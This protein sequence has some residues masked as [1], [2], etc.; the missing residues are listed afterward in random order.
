[1]TVAWHVI[2]TTTMVKAGS[3]WIIGLVLFL[4]LPSSGADVSEHEAR[5]KAETFLAS[6]T[7]GTRSGAAMRRVALNLNAVAETDLSPL[8][9][10]NR[11]GGGYVVVSGDS[12]TAEILAFS[13]TGSLQT[14]RMPANLRSCLERYARRIAQIPATAPALRSMAS[15]KAEI[16]PRMKT[17]WDQDDPYNLFTPNLHVVWKDMVRDVHAATGCVATGMAQ[18]LYYYQYPDATMKATKAFSGIA[19]VPVGSKEKRVVED[20]VRVA[21]QAEAVPEGSVIDW[22]NITAVYD[23]WSTEKECEA[24]ARLMQYC[25]ASVWMHYGMESGA[26]TDSMTYALYETFGYRDVYMIHSIEYPDV[27]SWG[28]AVY[29]E[30]SQAGPCPFSG[31]HSPESSAAQSESIGHLWILDGY[32]YV[33]GNDYFYSNWGWSGECNGYYLLDVMSPDE[34]MKDSQGRRVSYSDFQ[35]LYCGLGPNGEALRKGELNI[36]CESSVIGSEGK[37]YRRKDKASDF[38]VGDYLICFENLHFPRLNVIPALGIYDEA[39]GLVDYLPFSGSAGLSIPLMWGYQIY[40]ENER[41]PFYIGAGLENGVYDIVPICKT[42]EEREWRWMQNAE[43]YIVRM[44][45]KGNQATFGLS[46]TAIIPMP[47]S[48]EA[49]TD[50]W[51]SLSGTRYTRQPSVKGLYIKDGRK[52]FVK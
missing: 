42:P 37:T 45:V 7:A 11:E 46:P 24:V 9:A 14:E 20:T 49:E 35:S 6:R 44:T 5:R 3:R 32:R 47:H 38:E 2:W 30:L 26:R 22:K 33:D 16:K 19:D 25:G 27:R 8:Y 23:V 41:D 21:W 36:Y 34:Q 17:N 10:F 29:E 4:A 18:I 43:N 40:P 52:V 15:P 50:V 13:E 48:P 28:D 31:T 1:M 39:G 12:R 51:Y